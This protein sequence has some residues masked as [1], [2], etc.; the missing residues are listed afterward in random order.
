MGKSLFCRLC[1]NDIFRKIPGPRK[2]E[3]CEKKDE[4]NESD[5][6]NVIDEK[7]CQMVDSGP[8]MD[9]LF[10]VVTDANSQPKILEAIKKVLGDDENCYDENFIKFCNKMMRGIQMLYKQPHPVED[11]YN[12]VNGN[13][14]ENIPGLEGKEKQIV[15]AMFR[16]STTYRNAYLKEG[17]KRRRRRKSRSKSRRKSRKT[18]RKRRKSRKTKKRR[19][20]RR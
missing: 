8:K 2:C 9:E 3:D 18:K 17:G 19:R 13:S 6:I 4:K 10:T 1:E 16:L 5:E 12:L 11:M 15:E 14:E 20:R 7:D